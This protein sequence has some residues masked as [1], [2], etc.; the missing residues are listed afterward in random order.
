MS[1][2]G[3]NRTPESAARWVESNRKEW[4]DELQKHFGSR[5]FTAAEAT[6][7]WCCDISNTRYRLRSLAKLGSIVV[8]PGVFYPVPTPWTYRLKGETPC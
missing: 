4:L 7:L 5:S 8:T 3:G 6:E 1:P 2:R